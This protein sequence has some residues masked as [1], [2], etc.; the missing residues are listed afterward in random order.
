METDISLNLSIPAGHAAEYAEKKTAL[1]GFVD[2]AMDAAP[3]IDDLIGGNPRQIMY[4]NHRNHA[5]F[6]SNVLVLGLPDLLT[7]VL[8]WVY[9]TYAAH[10]FSYDYFPRA[11]SA[12]MDAVRA[13]L[14]SE[15]CE[16]VLPVYD[17]MRWR[18]ALTRAEE[19]ALPVA[20][21][22]IED[23]RWQPIRRDYLAAVLACDTFAARQIAEAA[24]HG[25]DDMRGFYLQVLQPTMYEIGRRWQT[26]DLSVAH[27]HLASA[28]AGRVMAS[29]YVR[30][31]NR[32]PTGGRAVITASPNELHELGA[33]MVADLLEL[34]GWDTAFLGADTPA[35]ELIQLLRARSCDLLGVSVTMPFNL[36]K[37]AALIRSIRAVPELASLK[38]MIGGGAFRL[39]PGVK[40]TVQADGYAEDA[41]AAVTLAQQWREAA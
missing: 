15:A 37:V 12:W 17:W 23:G 28:I 13:L 41:G 31:L 35:D 10:G 9:H 7:R 26:G 32:R 2:R 21:T 8:P 40:D 36:D 4:T 39:A 38:I 27:E 30:H 20:A 16:S 6:M 25:P 19:A 3:R 33:R 5:D 22:A 29:F 18:H 1:A 24:V 14:S 34:D 11:L